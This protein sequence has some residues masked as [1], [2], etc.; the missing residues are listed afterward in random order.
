[1]GYSPNSPF[2]F[3]N[4]NKK[5]YWKE[6]KKKYNCSEKMMSEPLQNGWKLVKEVYKYKDLNLTVYLLLMRALLTKKIQFKKN[7]KLDVYGL[8]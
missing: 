3:Q 1:M 8:N 7:P 2:L 6:I 5:K 4:K